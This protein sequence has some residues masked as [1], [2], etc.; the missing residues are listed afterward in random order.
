MVGSD[1]MVGADQPGRFLQST[2]LGAMHEECIAPKFYYQFAYSVVTRDVVVIISFRT[3][4][5]SVI[6]SS[7]KP[8]SFAVPGKAV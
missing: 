3:I 6:D 5:L 2:K 7:T 8:T 4:P 1:H